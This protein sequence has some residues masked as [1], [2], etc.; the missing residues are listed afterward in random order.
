MSMYFTIA[1]TLSPFYSFQQSDGFGRFIVVLL[2][3]V[4]IYAWYLMV[5][6]WLVFRE[7]S[8]NCERFLQ[9]INKSSNIIR[10]K[11]QADLPCS[12]QSIHKAGLVKLK[13]IHSHLDATKNLTA[14]ESEAL[15]ATLERNV[16]NQ[17]SVME[18]KM[19]LLATVVTASPFFGLLG[20]V[21]GV[22]MAFAG[23]AQQ[24]H[25]DINAIAPGISG[26]LLTTVV[27]LLVAIPSMIG[28]NL[29]L[30]I[31]K[32]KTLQMDNFVDNFVSQAI[33]LKSENR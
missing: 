10:A 3:T 24:G 19:G 5:D 9:E 20:T 14:M 4:S 6:K 17:L 33:I 25:A 21:W 15:R 12:L 1:V 2:F 30:N 16:D 26:A 11:K 8:R 31:L 32:R 7:D 22:M 13:E 27:G 18:D 29:L 28:Y 23:M